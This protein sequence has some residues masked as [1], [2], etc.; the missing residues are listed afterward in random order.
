LSLLITPEKTAD[1]A[2]GG[3]NS[4]SETIRKPPLVKAQTA[5]KIKKIWQKTIFNMADAILTPC[6]GTLQCHRWL[7]YD[8]PLNSP[9][10]PPYWNSTAGFDFDHIAAVAMSFCTSLRNFI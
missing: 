8:M 3:L 4:V 7:W 1:V 9:K 5:L 6:N 10:R 2:S